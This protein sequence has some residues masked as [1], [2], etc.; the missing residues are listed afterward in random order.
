MPSFVD[1]HW[2][3]IYATAQ[4]LDLPINFHIG[5]AEIDLDK[6]SASGIEARRTDVAEL[7]GSAAALRLAKLLMGQTDWIGKLL[8]SGVCERYPR[9]TFVAVETGFGHLPFYLE[10]LDWQVKGHGSKGLP[11]LPSEYFRRQC[12]G[13]F[14]FESL[15]LPLLKHYPDNFMFSTDYPHP[16]SLSPGPCGPTDLMPSEY[17]AQK[18]VDLDPALAKKVLSENAAAV[19]KL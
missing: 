6:M 1:P 7:E 3:P 5:F 11:L 19:Y 2:N 12:Y 13:T 17:V 8:M 18:Y 4:E 15:S 14:W 16:T 9:L 10:T